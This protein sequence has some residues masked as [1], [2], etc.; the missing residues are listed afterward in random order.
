MVGLPVPQRAARVYVPDTSRRRQPMQ[1]HAP[2]MQAIVVQRD[3]R[4]PES[5]TLAERLRPEPAA[6]EILI[7]VRAAGVNRADILQRRGLYPPPP[8]APGTLG[9]EAAGEVVAVGEGTARWKLGDRAAVL[10]AGGGYAEFVAVD[11]RHALP[12]PDG[13]EWAQAAALPET[14]FTVWANVFE[15]GRLQPGETLLVH[16]ATSGIGVTAILTARLWG[17]RVLG[18]ARGA[19]K[20]AG[21]EA[22][23]AEL[24]ADSTAGDWLEPITAAGGADVILDMV[25]GDYVQRNLQALKPG[26][27][28]VNIAYQAGAKVELDLRPVMIKRLTVTGSTL[29]GRPADEKARLA[30]A[31]E[32]RL[33]PWVLDGRLRLPLAATFPLAEAAAAHALMES[34]DNIGKIVLLA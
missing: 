24:V 11:A 2:S 5:L 23:G 7:R 3:G 6:G 22:L 12:V 31:V 9:L 1:A 34:G 14:L 8:G 17:A 30:E 19:A 26:G 18:T 21:A 13:L 25:G 33:W 29:R 4:S 10:L 28:L 15:S 20:A 16:G 27:R 32:G